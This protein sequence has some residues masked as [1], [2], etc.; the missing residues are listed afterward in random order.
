[1][2]GPLRVLKHL[3]M[4]LRTELDK[5]ARD[6]QEEFPITET[7]VRLKPTRGQGDAGKKQNATEY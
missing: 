1:M 6:L 7:G 3:T 5:T 2:D 4:N